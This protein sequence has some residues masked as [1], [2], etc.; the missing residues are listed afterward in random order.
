V[1]FHGGWF[2]HPHDVTIVPVDSHPIVAECGL[3]GASFRAE[4]GFWCQMD[5]VMKTGTVIAQR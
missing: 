5:F 4:L 2:T 3:P 1:K